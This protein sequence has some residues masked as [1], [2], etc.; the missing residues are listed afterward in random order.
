MKNEVKCPI[1][2]RRAKHNWA[3]FDALPREV[4]DALNYS[5]FKYT[6]TGQVKD[7]PALAR[8]IIAGDAAQ[9][10]AAYSQRDALD[11]LKELGL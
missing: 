10:A 4:R 6:V 1:K 5:A 7:G 11:E 3:A 8:K 9:V 2:M